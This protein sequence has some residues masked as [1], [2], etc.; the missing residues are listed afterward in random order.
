MS[1]K[2][3][4]GSLRKKDKIVSDRAACA[5][6]QRQIHGVNKDVKGERTENIA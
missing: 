3:E 6:A 2:K 4:G 5:K 1:L